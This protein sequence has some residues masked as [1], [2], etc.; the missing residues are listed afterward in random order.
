MAGD[1]RQ[2]SAEE[3]TCLV[4]CF[5]HLPVGGDQFFAWHG[6]WISGAK[7]RVSL[8][9][10]FPGL[11]SGAS[12]VGLFFIPLKPKTGL[13]GAP[14]GFPLEPTA[15]LSGL[16][17]TRAILRGDGQSFYPGQLFAFHKLE[18]SAAAGGDM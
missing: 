5:V 8:R 10:I 18:R 13:S 15:G 12:T 9:A 7:A 6:F 11:K 14:I 16:P 2:K 4:G 1:Q 3:V 17:S